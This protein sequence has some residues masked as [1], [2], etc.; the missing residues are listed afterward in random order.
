M[1][2][3]VPEKAENLVTGPGGTQEA[4]AAE[5]QALAGA[6]AGSLTASEVAVIGPR[7][8]AGHQGKSEQRKEG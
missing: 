5:D 8:A 3:V 2:G 6:T 7:G 4:C 1:M